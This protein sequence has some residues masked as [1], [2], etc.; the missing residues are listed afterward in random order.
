MT[1]SSTP[2]SVLVTGAS[3]GIGRAATLA[4][5]AEGFRVFAGIRGQ[6]AADRLRADAP[7]DHAARL[8]AVALDVTNPAQIRAVVTQVEAAV[9]DRG[10][11]GLFNNA[12]IS[13]NGP[14]EHLAIDGLRRQ[15]EVNLV[16]QVAVT[17]AFIPLLRRARGRIVSTGSVAGFIALPGL[18]P[19]AMS[20]HAMEGFSDSL[21]RELRPWGIEVSLLEPGAIATEIWRKGVDDA[22]AL[23]REYPPQVLEQYAPLIR[24]LRK[25]AGD[26]ARRASPPELVARDVVHAFSAVRPRTRYLVGR[27]SGIQRWI[28]RL[29]D[30]WADALLSKA[31]GL[32]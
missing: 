21:R 24:A 5:L 25:A 32:K 20:K 23:E 6:A 7:T 15:L 22:D 10:L 29:P 3:T 17:Q 9:G 18:G 26:S 19:Y 30:R 16:G 12:G 8:E 27:D 2:R 28:S 31:L 4:L 1:A 11:W 13:V 14:T